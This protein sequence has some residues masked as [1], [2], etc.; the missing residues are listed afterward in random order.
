MA[1]RVFVF[2]LAIV[3]C[4]VTASC[5][6][7]GGSP[8]TASSPT[9]STQAPAAAQKP[10]AAPETPEEP[11]E[12]EPVQE[13]I[14]LS[15]GDKIEND[16]FTMTFDSMEILSEYSYK[17][18]EYSSTSLYVENGYKLLLVR[19]HFD[20]T[21]TSVISDSCFVRTVVVNDSYTV[22]D[23]DVRL[24]FK[25]DKYFEIDPYTDLDYFLYINIPEKLADQFE[26]ATFTLAFNDDMSL[27]V[28]VFNLD[29][30]TTTTMDNLYSITSGE[31]SESPSEAEPAASQETPQPSVKTILIGDKIETEDF[32][33]TLNNV[34]LTY[35]LKP[36]NTSSVYTSYSAPDGKVYI[37]VDGSYYNKAK[38]DICIRDLFVPTADYDSGYTYRGFA[39]VDKDDNDFT[40][41]S[42]YVVCTPLETCHYHGLIECPKVID[43]SDAPLIVVFEIGGETYQ[44]TIR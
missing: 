34:E 26:T 9:V 31:T 27:P 21:S 20:N 23:Y 29:G 6:E 42:S 16:N 38:K 3:L 40:W 39:V 14:A 43:G 17:T 18:S 13:P 28:T 4:L 2:L 10:A 15:I 32:E 11:E 33:F 19:G 8:T 44:Y 25:R 36:Q 1:K 30:T 24:S 12:P 22:S 7:S 5:A 37:H 35:E 41:A